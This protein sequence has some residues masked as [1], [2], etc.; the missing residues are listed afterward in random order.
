MN[1]PAKLKFAH[2]VALAVAQEIVNALSLSCER[3]IIAGSLR[4]EKQWVGDIE[5]LYISKVVT[6]FKPG[7]MFAQETRFLAED[8]LASL[9]ASK[10][11]TMRINSAGIQTWGD[12]NKLAVH[13]A[14]GI[15]VDLFS[16]TEECWF[17][18]LICRTGSAATNIS[19]AT[20]AQKVG[21]K[22]NPYGPGFITIA[23]DDC[24]QV[25]SEEDLFD[26]LKM[27]CLEPKDR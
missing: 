20:R 26:F 1:P 22:W 13:A 15:P 21:W 7:D 3:I 10:A 25:T 9:L 16:T 27:P 12:K 14:S 2:S 11:L 19:I 17:N 18:S 8:H 24:R 4:R 5:I 23:G 6:G